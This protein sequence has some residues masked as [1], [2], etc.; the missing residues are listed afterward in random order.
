MVST[1]FAKPG[2]VGE[3][4]WYSKSFRQ[5][6]N[7]TILLK[8]A[9]KTDVQH[10]QMFYTHVGMLNMYGWY[11]YRG[12]I[13]TGVLHRQAC[14]TDRRVTQ[15]GVLHIPACYTDRR[16]TQTGVLHRQA[17]YTD[18]RVTQTGVLH[19]QMCYTDRRARRCSYVGGW[20]LGEIIICF[21][22][23]YFSGLIFL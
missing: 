23:L 19:R 1:K 10:R 8:C 2:I 7:L 15:T 13:Q 6:P 5:I 9:K 16:V 21:K 17:C 4:F 18:R 3:D 14:Y 12:V 11:T 22:F 20:N